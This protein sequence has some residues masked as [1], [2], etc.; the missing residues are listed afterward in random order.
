MADDQ[1][2][3]PINPGGMCHGASASPTLHQ[4][5]KLVELQRLHAKLFNVQRTRVQSAIS[6]SPGCVNSD[7]RYSKRRRRQNREAAER[8]TYPSCSPSRWNPRPN[9]PLA[10][11][12]SPHQS[13]RTRERAGH[14]HAPTRPRPA[15]VAVAAS[16][17][18]DSGDLA[19]A[20]RQ[21]RSASRMCWTHGGYISNAWRDQ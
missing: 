13:P 15:P 3:C 4:S 8:S 10:A 6:S 19:V 16:Y 1:R 12:S 18:K 21:S 9:S 14:P 11:A 17:R 5:L 7:I 20:G 2:C